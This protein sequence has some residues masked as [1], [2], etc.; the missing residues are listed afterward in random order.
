MA[1]C[2]ICGKPAAGDALMVAGTIY[3]SEACHARHMAAIAQGEA[4]KAAR[5]A[6]AQPPAL[7]AEGIA[8]AQR[9]SQL[10]QKLGSIIA[11]GLMLML[12]L[13]ACKLFAGC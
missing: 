4:V 8:T 1:R 3:C 9:H 12:A 11:T 13:F 5:L 2:A 7:T 10:A 6:A